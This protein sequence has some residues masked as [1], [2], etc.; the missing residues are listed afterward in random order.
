MISGKICFQVCAAVWISAMSGML[1]Q[2]T[3]HAESEALEMGMVVFEGEVIVRLRGVTSLPAEKRAGAVAG[4][5]EALAADA[6]RPLTSLRV[7]PD[8]NFHRIMAGD[9]MLMAISQADADLEGTTR[10]ALAELTINKIREAVIGYRA[11]RQPAALLQGAGRGLLAL[12][13]MTGLLY[14]LRFLFARLEH[15]LRRVFDRKVSDARVQELRIVEAQRIWLLVSSLLR[16][17]RTV[18]GLAVVL[19]CANYVLGCFPW[20]R[21]LSN[22]LFHVLL[23][24]LRVMAE[25]T[26][27]A[28]PGLAF[29]AVLAIVT[30][31]LVVLVKLIFRAVEEGNLKIRG[32]EPE[33]AMPTFR[34]LRFV[35]IAFALVV[36]YPYLPGSDSAAFKGVSLFLGV[37]FSLGSS[38]AISNI[39]AGYSL[40][41]RRAFRVGDRVKIGESV[42]VVTEV[43]LQVTHLR[44]KKNEELVIPNSVI[45]NSPVINYSSYSVQ[46]GLI[47]HTTVGIGYETPWRQVEAMLM[48]AA[49]GTPGLLQEPPPFVFA[50][51]LT[52]FAVNYQLNVYCGDP[53]EQE[54]LYAALHT[55][56]LDAFNKY[57]VQIMTPHYEG[58]PADAKVVPPGQWFVPPAVKSEPS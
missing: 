32:F 23:D 54:R 46:N 36:A 20:T 4:R 19:L 57:G 22:R 30:R 16:F 43:R 56:I 31:Y 5:I 39:I 51:G 47:L 37:M 24:P 2:E 14:L 28:V 17:L 10:G 12:L 6:R 44:T 40:I 3:P 58:D 9:T 55:S 41:Y 53:L 42:G 38:S 18:T 49:R 29:V 26:L 25:A 50:T 15:G 7:V 13:V 45:L 35:M 11:A 21:P 27:Q 33:W 1:A 8:E 48:E 52:D 34:V